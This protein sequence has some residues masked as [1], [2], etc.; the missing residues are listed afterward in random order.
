MLRELRDY[1]KANMMERNPSFLNKV[2]DTIDKLI[3]K[4]KCRELS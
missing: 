4:R 1:A 2:Q 3:I